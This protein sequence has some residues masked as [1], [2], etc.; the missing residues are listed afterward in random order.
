VWVGRDASKPSGLS[1]LPIPPDVIAR[2][3]PA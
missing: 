1:A 2:F 3:K